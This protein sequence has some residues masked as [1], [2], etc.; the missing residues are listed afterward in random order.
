M[1]VKLPVNQV[2]FNIFHLYPDWPICTPHPQQNKYRNCSKCQQVKQRLRLDK[3]GV[4]VSGWRRFIGTSYS[5]TG[6][7]KEGFP[8]E[9]LWK[10]Q[11]EQKA[12]IPQL[13]SNVE[14]KGWVLVQSYR[15]ASNRK[16]VLSPEFLWNIQGE[17]PVGRDRERW[18]LLSLQ[19]RATVKHAMGRGNLYLNDICSVKGVQSGDARNHKIKGAISLAFYYQGV[20]VWGQLGSRWVLVVGWATWVPAVG[21]GWAAENKEGSGVAGRSHW[22]N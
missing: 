22:E 21:R 1:T 7:M 5:A 3:R 12:R 14:N 19:F 15:E 17:I 13:L 20:S 16:R 18:N 6:N 8:L 4:D 9:L 2:S 11:F 10:M